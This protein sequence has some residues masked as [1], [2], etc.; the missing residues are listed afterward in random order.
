MQKWKDE[1]PTYSKRIKIQRLQL[2]MDSG[3]LLKLYGVKGDDNSVAV[4]DSH[5]AYENDDVELVD[6]NRAGVPLA[7]IITAPELHSAH[8]A[9]CFVEQLRA[10]LH[11]NRICTGDM[12][13]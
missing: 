6:L 1:F 3:K 10:F 11:H 12:H 4:T 7:E 5:N 2:E 13:S 9:I 8:E